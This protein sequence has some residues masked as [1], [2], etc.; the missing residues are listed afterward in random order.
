[1]KRKT[2]TKIGILVA[3]VVLVVVI[4]FMSGNIN[5]DLIET[6]TIN[7]QTVAES[8]YTDSYIVRNETLISNDTDGYVSYVFDDGGKVAVGGVIAYIYR[9]EEDARNNKEIEKINEE[10]EN[11]KRLNLS[12]LTV[13]TGL[14][15]IN[16]RLNDEIISIN[17]TVN[18]SDFFNIEEEKEELLYF[19]N[20]RQIIIGDVINYNE[21]IN[22]LEDEKQKL[23][24]ES[25]ES[26]GVITSP[27]AGYFTPSVDGYEGDYE[28]SKVLDMSKNN[29][30]KLFENE[31]HKVNDDV[32]GKVIS[33]LNWYINCPITR[34]DAIEINSAGYEDIT[35]YMPYAT[36][37]A[38]PVKIKAVN[39]EDDKSD[40]VIVLECNYMSD[41]I[42]NL[43]EETVQIDVKSYTGFAVNKEALHEETI[44]KTTT[45][46]N[47][48]EKEESKKV[49]GVYVVKGNQLE[50]K[51]V[52]ILYAIND[53]YIC[54]TGTDLE[55]FFR[56]ETIELYDEVVIGGHD[57]YEGKIIQS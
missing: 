5:R 55:E 35:L 32:V 1:M 24:N 27:V 45:D 42:A 14:D 6:E 33:E 49:M 38:L 16:N 11:Y 52:D 31:P 19:I 46:E 54:D 15:T 30:D 13:S 21:K 50:F 56:G 36:S 40:A 8:I 41:E 18:K 47:G 48:N 26:I 2:F 37:R 39:Q 51:E 4:I 3:I 34:D 9:T 43:R 29:L 23:E 7:I 17:K 44:T 22:E 12:T 25:Q 10:I 57:L 53:I 28:Y 20:E